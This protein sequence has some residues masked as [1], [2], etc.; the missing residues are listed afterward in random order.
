MSCRGWVEEARQLLER[1]NAVQLFEHVHDT[2]RQGR[3]GQ[4]FPGHVYA[5]TQGLGYGRPGGAWAARREAIAGGLYDRHAIGGGDSAMLCAWEGRDNLPQ[6]LQHGTAW[7]AY[8]YKWAVQSFDQVRGSLACVPGDV[9]HLFH[10][11]RQNR[12]YVERYRIFHENAYDPV[13][14]VEIDPETGLLR[15]SATARKRKPDLV[16]RV[17][18][19]FKRRREDE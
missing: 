12:Q 19:Y 16:W 2:D 15:W 7:E 9:V 4:R 17:A 6:S 8:Y 10:G 3:L 18:E 1:Y 14:D 11:S 13:G 5:R